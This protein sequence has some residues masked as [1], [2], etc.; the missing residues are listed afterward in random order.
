MSSCSYYLH[1]AG[2]KQA[3][4]FQIVYNGVIPPEARVPCVL[5]RKHQ[6]EINLGTKTTS[7]F[8]RLY[9]SCLCQ[10]NSHEKLLSWYSFILGTKKYKTAK[11]EY[12]DWATELKAA[13]NQEKKKD[14]KMKEKDNNTTKTR[15]MK[16]QVVVEIPKRV[17]QP[18]PMM[19]P[20]TACNATPGPSGWNSSPIPLPPTPPPTSP[21]KAPND[22][23]KRRAEEPE[24]A[25]VAKRRKLHMLGS[26]IELT[27]SEEDEM[28]SHS[29]GKSPE[30]V[31]LT[32]D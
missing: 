15:K 32:Q 24:P 22:K 1:F 14:K 25:P 9:F 3:K 30:I 20:S 2:E 26:P 18:F 6:L 13:K 28:R 27:D 8:G 23:G 11:K 21:A 5:G 17:P 29:A 7:N 31:D 10:S 16:T 12:D 4:L 19:P